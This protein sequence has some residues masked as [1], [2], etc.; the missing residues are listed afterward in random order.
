GRASVEVY[1]FIGLFT[2]TT[3]A[4]AGWAREQVCTYMCPLPR[5]QAAMLDEHSMIFT[6]QSWR[7]EPRGKHKA[8]QSWDG[9]GDCIDC[10]L[11]V[12]VCP[13]GIDIR[14]GQQMECIGC[15]LCIDACNETM[16]KVGRPRDL[17]RWD[18]LA[19]QEDREQ[20]KPPAPWRPVR[21][22][23][24]LYAALLMV[25]AAVMVVAFFLRGTADLSVQRDRSPN[26]VRLS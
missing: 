3:Y 18:T 24:L 13:T 4:L 8:G 14:D 9:R 6:Y 1:F 23:T 11:C 26:F 5:F 12:N 17:I 15:G 2:A 25:V 21:P 20:G 7:G 16:D 22:R 19:R 10:R